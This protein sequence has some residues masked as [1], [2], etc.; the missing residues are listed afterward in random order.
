MTSLN[1]IHVFGPQKNCFK[2]VL[3]QDLFIV[4]ILK[5]ASLLD[6]VVYICV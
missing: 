1:A 6:L 2:W 4:N 3:L 5:G